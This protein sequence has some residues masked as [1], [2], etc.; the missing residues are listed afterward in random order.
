MYVLGFKKWNS[1]FDYGLIS[2]DWNFPKYMLV[3]IYNT[4]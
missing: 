3:A 2:A 1:G 4:V